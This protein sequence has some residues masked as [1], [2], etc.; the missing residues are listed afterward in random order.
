MKKL[1]K[2]VLFIALFF[3]P[4]FAIAMLND[5]SSDYSHTPTGSCKIVDISTHRLSDNCK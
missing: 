3:A 5:N 2:H 4:V 1:I